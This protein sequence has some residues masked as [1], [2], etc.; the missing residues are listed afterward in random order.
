MA[1]LMA[2]A[3]ALAQPAGLSVE[4]PWMRALPNH[5]PAAGYFRIDNTGKTP[6]VLVGAA[7]PACGHLMLHR[8]VTEGGTGRME[9][10]DRVE[11]P[12]GGSLS[13]APGG[14][15]LMCMMPTAAVTPGHRVPVTLTFDGGSTLDVQ[16]DVRNAT[17]K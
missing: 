8:T 9:M 13:F 10:V 7:S 2:G 6:A 16:F 11:V 3:Q 1:T 12:A 15:H 14:Y 4:D 17:G 5:L